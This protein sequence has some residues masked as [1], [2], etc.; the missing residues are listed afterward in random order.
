MMKSILFIALSLLISLNTFAQT[1]VTQAKPYGEK[2]WGYINQKG[3]TII[4]PT[5]KKCY[6]FSENGLATIYESK[7]FQ[8]I[9]TKGEILT[10]DIEGFKLIEGY[11]GFGG[12]QGFSDGMVAVQKSKSWGF[13]NSEGV[14][15]IML[16][17]E[18]VSSFNNG[19]AVAQGGGDFF[20]IDKINAC[21]QSDISPKTA[22]F[23]P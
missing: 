2:L 23:I 17:Y 4:E 12:L 16:K 5:Y 15:A 10:T 1:Y 14:V 9:N 22:V 3:E 11:L 6:K 8:F 20:V 18:K 13:L 7:K 19:F 21:V